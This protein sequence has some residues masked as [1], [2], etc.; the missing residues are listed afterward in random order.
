MPRG[1]QHETQLKASGQEPGANTAASLLSVSTQLYKNIRE[2]LHVGTEASTMTGNFECGVQPV[3]QPISGILVRFWCCRALALVRK[4]TPAPRAHASCL[5]FLLVHVSVL[6]SLGVHFTHL[7]G[8]CDR[9]I[10]AL[11]GSRSRDKSIAYFHGSGDLRLN[12]AM[13]VE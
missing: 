3:S 6:Q 11:P 8:T 12:A 13:S 9:C 7:I 10:Q 1:T 4:C 2:L 5:C